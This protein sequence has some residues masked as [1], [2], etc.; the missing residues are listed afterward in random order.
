MEYHI[1]KNKAVPMRDGIIL[2]ADL[3]MP[4]ADGVF[5]T[6]IMRTPYNKDKFD[7]E[8]LYSDP[9]AWLKEGYCLLIQDVRGCCRSEGIL[10]STGESEVEDGCDT[11]EWAAAQPWCDGNVGMYGLSYFGWTQYA[12]AQG[13]PPHLKAICPYMNASLL[14]FSV[15]EYKAIGGLHMYWLY[16]QALTRL[17]FLDM[18]EEWREQVRSALTDNMEHLD[19]LLFPLPLKDTKAAQVEGVPLLKDYI[20]LVEGA[21]KKDFWDRGH[22]PVNIGQMTTPMLHLTGWFDMAKD[23]T[24]RQ[25][26]EGKSNPAVADKQKLVIGPWFHGGALTDRIDD[27]YFGPQ[28]SGKAMDMDQMMIRWMDRWLKQEKNGIDREPE[29]LYFMLGSNIW[30]R[31]SAFPPKNTTCQTWYLD[32]GGQEGKGSLERRIPSREGICQYVYDPQNPLR[33]DFRDSQ[34]RQ[35]TAD[36]R[37]LEVREDMLSFTSAPLEEEI[38]VTGEV[39]LTLYA[40][41]T[42]VD[43]DFVCRLTDVWP[44]GRV[45]GYTWGMCRTR[46]SDGGFKPKLLTPGEKLRLEISLGFISACF[47]KG[48]R[49]GL[50]IMSSFYPAINRNTNSGQPCASATQCITAVQKIFCTQ[51]EPSALHLPVEG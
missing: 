41:T 17:D 27:L 51:T 29:V 16:G 9:Q 26:L 42:A 40:S 28:A 45:T 1:I 36:L 43:T 7:Q 18:D 21:E 35:L 5:P 22:H 50:Q 48:H 8:W 20:E 19:E 11:V 46:F 6:V 14:P 38:P 13:R 49:I 2:Y 39:K 4:A 47:Q 30:K 34:G 32:G 10:R 3:Y 25:Y 12:A 24:I 44:D 15:N 37:E 33:S 31:S 23:G